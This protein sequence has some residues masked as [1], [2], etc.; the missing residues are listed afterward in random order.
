[1]RTKAVDAVTALRSSIAHVM[2]TDRTVAGKNKKGAR[3]A[4][5]LEEANAIHFANQLYWKHKDPSPEAAAE[6]QHRQE[7]LEEIASALAAAKSRPAH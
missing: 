5:L 4:L 3:V 1:M 6:Y 2:D 7:R